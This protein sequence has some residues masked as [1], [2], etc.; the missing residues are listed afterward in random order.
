M[1]MYTNQAY[2]WIGLAQLAQFIQFITTDW[3]KEK[4]R[5]NS[6]REKQ[7]F[8][9]VD[10]GKKIRYNINT[11]KREREKECKQVKLEKWN[12]KY[13]LKFFQVECFKKQA[14]CQV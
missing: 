4:E 7:I 9:V 8:P 2:Y 14:V 3:L 1:R 13:L 6:C 5:E 11:S 12:E 10:C